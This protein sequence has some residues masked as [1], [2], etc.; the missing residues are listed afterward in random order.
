MKKRD[1]KGL[2][3]FAAIMALVLGGGMQLHAADRLA[4]T[5]Y[6]NGKIYTITETMEEA[7]DVR[8]A[9]KA[10]VVAT[11]NGKI[12]FV[13]SSAE[14]KQ[15]GYLDDANVGKI[16]DLRGKTMLPGFIDGHSHFPGD[17]SIDLYTVNLNC[18]P[19]G[20]VETMDDLIALMRAKADSTPDGYWV[21]G[22]NYDD[23]LIAEKRHPNRLD[24]DKASPTKPISVTHSS[25]HMSAVNSIVIE[26]ILATQGSVEFL[27]GAYIFKKKDGT[28]ESGVDIDQSTGIP[29]GV[30]R[31]SAAQLSNT[32]SAKSMPTNT[33]WLNARGSQKYAAAGVTTADIGGTGIANAVP[34][35]QQAIR[36]GLLNVRVVAHPSICNTA[37]H[38]ALKW[39]L[40]GTESPA[41]SNKN[42]ASLLD[43]KPT[44]D[45]PKMGADLT[46]YKAPNASKDVDMSGQP[47]NR[48][49]LGA[50]KQFYDG[51]P[52]GYTALFKRPGYWDKQGQNGFNPETNED[53]GPD[54]PL[55]GLGGTSKI[56]FQQLVES[57][58]L[59]HQYGQSVETHTN[60]PLAA[61]SM[62]TA[63]EL[64]VASN[65]GVTDTRH[66]FIHGQTEERQVVERAA[67]HYENLDTTAHM[68]TQ[69]NGTALQSGTVKAADGTEYTASSLR[70]ALDNGALVKNQNLLS[71]Y[72]INHTYF[73][74]DRHYNIYFGPGRAK[75]ISPAGWAAHFGHRFTSHNDTPVTPISPLR[76]INSFVN[77]ITTGGMILNGSSTD[78]TATAWYPETKGGAN[79]EFWDYD[80]RVNALQGIHA[81]T[82]NAAYQ[83]K[84]DDR[85]GSIEEGKLADFTILD[86][87][88]L[89]VAASAPL[90]L[91]DMR[92]ATTIVDDAVI[93]G[94][95][96]D[97]ESMIGQMSAGYNQP[98]GVTVKN[99]QYNAISRDEAE[100][101]YGAIDAGDNR[102]GTMSFTANVTEGKS[103]VFQMTFL[104]N[105]MSVDS[106]KL[107]KL[108]ANES[109]KYE[110]GKPSV[111]EMAS[112]SGRWWVMEMDT[113]ALLAPTDT[114]E[115]NKTY[116]AFFVIR[117]ND[118]VFDLDATPGVI[119]D[120]VSLATTGTMP[121]N[122][123]TEVPPSGNTE[124]KGGSSGGCTVGT[125]PAYDMLVLFLG[126]S[127]VAVIRVIRRKRSE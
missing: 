94:I 36:E 93:Y 112:A 72:F 60:G 107:Y 116:I 109:V 7:K 17:S 61:E 47:D 31:E 118:G 88:P 48:I 33:D 64:A 51:S 37:N 78:I 25:G 126:L 84:L 125:T 24:L 28:Y 103:G 68:Y 22:N 10:D 82:I 104:G 40:N 15:K 111:E 2:L 55:L 1:R 90:T 70:A 89:E 86:L 96:P 45:S 105:G 97:S 127:A 77:R 102:L 52:Q 66:T 92:V 124:D 58:N 14:A 18:P 59:Y 19:L 30:L 44:A 99:L 29:T 120:P 20:P 67:G 56:P 27:N 53:L 5:V 50:W 98:D 12:V 11:L 123:N 32:Y 80:Q 4:D 73:W 76:S 74:G 100:K 38:K 34:G 49:L 83:N 63:I 57:I 16:V 69:L 75:M 85:L 23:S 8:N 87:D 81:T 115:M 122:G 114:L 108:H 119:K 117:D 65:P 71:S 62:M 21:R 3:S 46:K 79:A 91:A 106:Y 39:D 110:Y 26:H 35:Y 95:L 13:G 54:G 43:D 121:N 41:A 9:K 101:N 6:H 42:L 113:L